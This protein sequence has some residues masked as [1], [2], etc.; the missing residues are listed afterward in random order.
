MFEAWFDISELQQSDSSEKIIMQEKQMNVLSVMHQ[1]GELDRIYQ[2]ICV[3]H[4]QYEHKICHN[5][6]STDEAATK[7]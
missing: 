6:K 4:K 5:S 3:K 1:V 2:Y 7:M